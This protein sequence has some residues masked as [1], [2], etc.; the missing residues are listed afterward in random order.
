V[1]T[2]GHILHSEGEAR[3]R[4]L[5]KKVFDALAPGGTIAIAS[6]LPDDDRTALRRR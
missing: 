2:L 4:K 5:L 6:S 3:S 1:A